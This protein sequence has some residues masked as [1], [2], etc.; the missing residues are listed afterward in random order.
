MED[1]NVLAILFLASNSAFTDI[2]KSRGLI[3]LLNGEY[4]LPVTV[5][6][7]WTVMDYIDDKIECHL[8]HFGL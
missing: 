5:T 8:K 1:D 3:T 2:L 7:D 6:L 4:W